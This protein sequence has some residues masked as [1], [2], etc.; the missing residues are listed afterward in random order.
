MA[1]KIVDP[2]EAAKVSVELAKQRY[3]AAAN[4][5]IVRW[6]A[7]DFETLSAEEN[8][9]YD[10]NVRPFDEAYQAARRNLDRLT[11]PSYSPQRRHYAFDEMIRTEIWTQDLNSPEFEEACA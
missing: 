2:I 11:R 6:G 10:L 4:D 3:E 1:T 7:C 8:A 5:Y 9:D